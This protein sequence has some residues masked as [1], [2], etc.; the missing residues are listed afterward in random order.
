MHKMVEVLEQFIAADIP[1]LPQERGERI[2][3]LKELVARADVSV[4]EKYRRILEAYQ[5]ESDYGRT[6]EAWRGELES[7]GETRTVEFLRVG[8]SMLYY[9][10]ADGHISGLWNESAK[11][12]QELPSSARRPLA[13]A[14]GIA[15]QQKSPDWLMLPVKTL[16]SQGAK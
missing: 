9:Q 3:M 7:K 11:E 2:G 13:S 10:T 12:W 15:R 6:L 4:A 16:A 14:L 5:I 1:F 8:R